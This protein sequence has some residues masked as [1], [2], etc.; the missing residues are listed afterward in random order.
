[1]SIDIVFLYSSPELALRMPIAFTYLPGFVTAVLRGMA[2]VR[3][4]HTVS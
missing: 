2:L 4:R 1:M 3:I